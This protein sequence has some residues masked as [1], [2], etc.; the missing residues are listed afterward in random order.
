M[1]KHYSLER[2][3]EVAEGDWNY[4]D[5]D[6]CSWCSPLEW[7]W[8]GVLGGC[9]C[10]NPDHMSQIAWEVLEFHNWDTLDK[11]DKPAES[12]VY[13]SDAH[14]LMAYWLN[15]DHLKLTE[16]GGSVAWGW[17]TPQGRQVYEIIKGL[18]DVER[19]R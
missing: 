10:G 16:H 1:D 18:L 19:E 9:G 4:K 13:K 11:A 5:Q 8:T 2:V 12:I 3:P 14:Y 17:L 7:L 15:L 6:G